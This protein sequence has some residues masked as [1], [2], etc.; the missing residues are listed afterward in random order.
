LQ[1]D[2]Q[3]SDTLVGKLLRIESGLP[4]VPV[5]VD[6][7]TAHAHPDNIESALHYLLFARRFDCAEAE[8]VVM[9]QVKEVAWNQ[10]PNGD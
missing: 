6:T 9:V 10:Q 7:S 4:A 8:M 5:V 2:N 1:R 3:S